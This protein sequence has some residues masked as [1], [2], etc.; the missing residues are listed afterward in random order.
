MADKNLTAEQL[1]EKL[2]AAENENAGLKEANAGLSKELADLKAEIEK[3]LAQFATLEATITDNE[4][5][6]K[7]LSEGLAEA[8]EALKNNQGQVS[9][10]EEVK[11]LK[12][13]LAT[14]QQ[15]IEQLN[16]TNEI[17]VLQ[18][19]FKTELPIRKINGK[20]FGFTA[21][22]F[23]IPGIGTIVSSE[24]TEEQIEALLQIEGQ[25]ILVELEPAAAEDSE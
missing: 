25:G 5:E 18:K 6:I 23:G 16:G 10:K 24:A 20:V 13:E 17:M 15:L 4:K 22:R 21:D 2:T 7:Y 9:L 19:K 3:N 14:A 12:E 8:K 1:Q 11:N